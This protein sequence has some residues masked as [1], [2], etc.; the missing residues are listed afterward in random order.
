MS[1]VM[2]DG[3]EINETAKKF[4]INWKA[5]KDARR[6]QKKQLQLEQPSINSLSTVPTLPALPGSTHSTLPERSYFTDNANPMVRLAGP[7]EPNQAGYFGKNHKALTALVQA[8]AP[9]STLLRQRGHHSDVSQSRYKNS[10]D[11]FV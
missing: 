9:H 10:N 5:N 11:I 2:L 1:T 3:K 6:K 4:L 7:V 8:R